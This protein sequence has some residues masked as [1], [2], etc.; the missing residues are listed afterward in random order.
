M[1]TGCV[2]LTS[3]CPRGGRRAPKERGGWGTA[4]AASH[5]RATPFATWRNSGAAVWRRP[6]CLTIVVRRVGNCAL[7]GVAPH[8]ATPLRGFRR[9]LVGQ[10]EVKNARGLRAGGN[11]AI[12]I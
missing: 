12:T 8:P 1:S 2:D 4:R 9:P 10:G 3:P 7:S 5:Q 6:E 11:I